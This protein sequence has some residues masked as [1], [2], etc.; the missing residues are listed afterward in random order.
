MDKIQRR[1]NSPFAMSEEP[2]TKAGYSIC[3]PTSPAYNTTRKPPKAVL[4][5]NL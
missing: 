3:P 5:P 2:R 1:P 4:W